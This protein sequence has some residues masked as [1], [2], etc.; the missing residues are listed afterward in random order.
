MKIRKL[1]VF[2]LLLS[3]FQAFSQEPADALRYSWLQPSGTART[4]AIGGAITSLGGDLTSTF[5]NPAGL[6]MYKTNEFVMTPGFSFSNNKADYLGSQGKDS[7]SG[8]HFGTTGLI[9]AAPGSR[10]G[11]W[12]NFSI[13][14]G[15]NRIANFNSGVR[16][17][18]TN[19]QSSYSEK[20][21]EELIND[22]VTDPNQAAQNYPYG[23]SLAFNTFLIDTVQ[24]PNGTVS[25]YRSLATPQTGVT[26]SQSITTKGGHY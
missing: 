7:K 2:I 14:L 19:N 4:Q 5:M 13:G 21:L 12:R 8:F 20:Y 15:L 18:G 17:S 16:I 26:Q 3:G 6:G 23:P 22:G 10:N 25:G 24:G 1:P 9:F 11:N